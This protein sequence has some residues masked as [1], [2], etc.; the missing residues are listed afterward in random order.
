MTAKSHNIAI[1]AGSFH[2][3]T[4]GHADI[5]RRGLEI[6]DRIII[7]VGVNIAKGTTA[8]TAVE[9]IAELYKDEPRVTV[10]T[11][12]GLT[13]ELAKKT[14]ARFLLRGVRSVKDYEYERDMAD[15]N[16]AVFGLETVILYA[17]PDLAYVSSSLVR[18]LQAYGEDVSRFLP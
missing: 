14:D 6:F 18:E 2:P 12:P 5:V 1:F 8:P 4:I 11:W 13:A 15:A 7:S 16:R 9:K 10:V 17:S 3:F